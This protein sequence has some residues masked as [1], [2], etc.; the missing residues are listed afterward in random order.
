MPTLLDRDI[1]L[2]GADRAVRRLGLTQMIAPVTIDQ[3]AV[4]TLLACFHDA[5]VTA[6]RCDFHIDA[7]TLGLC[8]NP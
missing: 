2:V 4:V 1:Q 8:L 3:I 7:V 5:I 6:R